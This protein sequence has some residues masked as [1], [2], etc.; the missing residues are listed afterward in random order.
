MYVHVHLG[1]LHDNYFIFSK[2]DSEQITKIVRFCSKLKPFHPSSGRSAMGSEPAQ[3]MF[4]MA[5]PLPSQLTVLNS[6]SVFMQY[7]VS[8]L[9]P[10]V[11]EMGLFKYSR[12]K[13][14]RSNV[15]CAI[16]YPSPDGYIKMTKRQVGFICCFV[17]H[18][19][20]WKFKCCRIPKLF[21]WVS[22]MRGTQQTIVCCAPLP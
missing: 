15:L 14:H 8:L 1:K 7:C 22:S 17:R 3:S 13:K 16:H 5:P 4:L 11:D 6:S 10:N 19:C 2:F 18:G 12:W 20:M 9:G 21:H